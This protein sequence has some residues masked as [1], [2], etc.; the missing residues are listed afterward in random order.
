MKT[1][2]PAYNNI[3]STYTVY[4]RVEIVG[5]ICNDGHTLCFRFLIDQSIIVVHNTRTYVQC[6]RRAPKIKCTTKI[7]VR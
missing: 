1:L 2:G 4:R 3:F 5:K 6:V 7:R